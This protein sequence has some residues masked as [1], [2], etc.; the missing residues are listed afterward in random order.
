MKN[1]LKDYIQLDWV[2]NEL[3]W[4]VLEKIPD[5]HPSAKHKKNVKALF[6]KDGT[7]K[8]KIHSPKTPEEYQTAHSTSIFIRKSL[9][10]MVERDRRRKR[11][12][13]I[14]KNID[15]VKNHRDIPKFVTLD[16]KIEDRKGRKPM[17]RIMEDKDKVPDAPAIDKRKLRNELAAEYNQLVRKNNPDTKELRR[18][19]HEQIK[20]LESEIG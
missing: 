15:D 6:N 9:R 17:R 13:M 1:N 7:P 12:D 8:A 2:T 18:Q 16:L 5:D 3:I 4:E 11:I 14:K 19:M 20:Q 10:H